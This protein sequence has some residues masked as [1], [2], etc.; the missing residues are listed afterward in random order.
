MNKKRSAV[1]VIE[2][3]NFDIETFVSEVP[4]SLDMPGIFFVEARKRARSASLSL[5]KLKLQLRQHRTR[6]KNTT[7]KRNADHPDDPWT[8]IIHGVSGLETLFAKTIRDFSVSDVLLVAAAESY[9][10]AIADH[11]L[12]ST[13]AALFD[14]LSPT[15]KWLFLPKVMSLDWNPDTSKG[16]LKEFAAVVARRNKIV[17]PKK[18]EVKGAASVQDFVERLR[19][20]AQVADRGI[21]AVGGLISEISLHWRGSY[22][23][24]LLQ[25]SV[26][27]SHPPCFLIGTPQ[28]PARLGR[29]RK[30]RARGV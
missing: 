30:P 5:D 8:E 11:V 13:D 29:A 19:M 1:D 15:G 26:A 10:N 18:I 3:P 21:S 14:K 28:S 20:N 9:I 7:K 16:H 25:Q 27:N 22:G 6:V 24:A 4:L 2:W 17:H 23:P 12:T